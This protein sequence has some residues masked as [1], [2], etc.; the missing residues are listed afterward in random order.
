MLMHWP[1]GAASM[2]HDHRNSSCW[3]KLLNGKPREIVYGHPSPE[4]IVKISDDGY[5]VTL[6][7]API[8]LR[9]NILTG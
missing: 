3:V 5:E 2:L 4:T 8:I 9:K 1:P 6:S 7:E